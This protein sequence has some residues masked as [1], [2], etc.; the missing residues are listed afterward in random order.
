MQPRLAKSDEAR[1]IA[2]MIDTAYLAYRDQGILL[3]DVS[4]GVDDAITAEQVWVVGAP[5]LQGVL[6]LTCTPPQ[7]HLMNV[8]V[9]PS[10]RG[11]GLGGLLIRHA[12]LLAARAGCHEIALAT[13]RDLTD[14]ISL[15]QHLGWRVSGRDGM[16]VMMTRPIDQELRR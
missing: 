12:L 3:P 1:A 10:G 14:N 4:G 7:A 8:A 11:T 16:R 5:D 9:A 2:Q 6:M 15:Y 13:H